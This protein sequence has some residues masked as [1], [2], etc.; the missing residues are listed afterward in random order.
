[1]EQAVWL[2]YCSFTAVIPTQIFVF[3]VLEETNCFV[4]KVTII[5]RPS[6]EGIKVSTDLKKTVLLQCWIFGIF[7]IDL[8]AQLD[9][10]SY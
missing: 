10:K 9:E 1:M 5:K 8:I 7:Y 6:K 3:I 4:P 2:Q